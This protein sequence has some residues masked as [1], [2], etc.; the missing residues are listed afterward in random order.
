MKKIIS[1]LIVLT[2]LATGVYFASFESPTKVEASVNCEFQFSICLDKKNADYNACSA[3]FSLCLLG[4]GPGGGGGGGGPDFCAA[5]RARNQQCYLNSYP[6]DGWDNG[7]PVHYETYGEC[8][9]ASGVDQ[10]E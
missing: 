5:A 1:K 2:V 6:Y 8:R 9:L 4:Q 7:T 3:E 10:C